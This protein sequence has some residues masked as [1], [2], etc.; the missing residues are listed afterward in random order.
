M[1]SAL[2]LGNVRHR[3]YT[4]RRHRFAYPL[5][6]LYADLDELE[7]LQ[8]TSW[9][10]STR[11]L[12]VAWLRRRDYF[13]ASGKKEPGTSGGPEITWAEEVRR[14]VLERTG[15]YPAG[16]VRLLTHPRT[17]G[18]RM[19][20]VSLFYCHDR[21]GDLAAVVAEVTNTPWDESHLYVVENQKAED[22][23][24]WESRFPK[25]LHVSPFF[26]MDHEYRWLVR[27][28]GP[29][30]LVHMENYRQGSK[31]FDATLH[32]ERRPLTRQSLRRVL[33][34]YPAMTLRVFLW[35]YFQAARLKLAGVPFHSHPG[36]P[37]PPAKIEEGPA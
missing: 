34:R 27:P 10:L 4:P 35:I 5:F 18:F 13:G 17:L 9:L 2:Y 29:K 7:E 25:A 26:P 36:H 14:L 19:N 20:P 1:E 33:L 28:P 24:T 30:L 23:G 12:A 11:R 31:V 6:L 3:R 32:L 16:A 22:G 15:R 21:K 37:E 8:K